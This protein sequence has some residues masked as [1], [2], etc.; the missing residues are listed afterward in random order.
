MLLCALQSPVALWEMQD[1]VFVEFTDKQ[2]HSMLLLFNVAD[3]AQCCLSVSPEDKEEV[4]HIQLQLQDIC[5]VEISTED[6]KMK[7]VKCLS[8]IGRS[9]T[10]LLQTDVCKQ[11]RV[12]AAD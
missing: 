8:V 5:Q 12:A 11:P 1:L 10:F 6:V 7:D 4:S 3:F 2:P 9:K